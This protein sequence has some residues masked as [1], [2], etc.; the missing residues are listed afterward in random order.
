[1]RGL[2]PDAAGRR[3]AG[4]VRPHSVSSQQ[5]FLP[6][7]SVASAA[8]QVALS[9]SQPLGHGAVVARST[10]AACPLHGYL[11]VGR[12]SFPQPCL[13]SALAS[14]IRCGNCTQLQVALSCRSCPSVSHKRLGRVCGLTRRSSGRPVCV[15]SPPHRVAA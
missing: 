2:T 7:F 1:M 9:R 5:T 15:A 12:T 14:L 4:F 13:R 6:S 3:L 10:P 11:P 8:F